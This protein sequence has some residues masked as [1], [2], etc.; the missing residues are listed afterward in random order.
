MFPLPISFYIYAGIALVSAFCGFYVE[1]LRF[2]NYQTQVEAIGKQAEEHTKAVIA[3][4]QAQT[5][6]IANDYKTKLDSINSYYGR[7]R[8]SSSG[9]VSASS[10]TITFP[11]GSTKDFISVAQDCAATTQQLVSLQQ[12]VNEQVGIK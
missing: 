5:E 6:R 12:W 3:E 9:T 4:Q 10:Q 8:Q 7:M 1:H 11:D 2:E